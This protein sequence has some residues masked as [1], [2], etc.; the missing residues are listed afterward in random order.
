MLTYYNDFHEISHKKCSLTQS[1][2]LVAV[3]IVSST[4]CH[5]LYR[6][7]YQFQSGRGVQ[8]EQMYIT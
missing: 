7:N 8:I 5:L 4:H 2:E 3:A 1:A 6:V